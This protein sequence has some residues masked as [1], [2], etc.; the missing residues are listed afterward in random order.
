MFAILLLAALVLMAFGGH[1]VYL[2]LFSHAIHPFQWALQ[3]ILLVL[4]LALGLRLIALIGRG[5]KA[6]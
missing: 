4:L 3:A 5:R 1:A 2:F 6:E